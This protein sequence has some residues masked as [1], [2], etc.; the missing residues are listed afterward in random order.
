MSQE[1]DDLIRERAHA[2]WQAEGCPDGRQDQHWQQA[3]A[4]LSQAQAEAAQGDETV[5][6]SEDIVT[7]GQPSAVAKPASAKTKAS[8]TRAPRKVADPAPATAKG[9]RRKGA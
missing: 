2:I 1:R 6:A 8:S 9:R 4:E 5:L 3:A 7:S